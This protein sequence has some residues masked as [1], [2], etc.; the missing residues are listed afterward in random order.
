MSVCS[1]SSLLGSADLSR[2][3]QFSRSSRLLHL[4]AASRKVPL[5]SATTFPKRSSV[6]TDACCFRL[7]SMHLPLHS[8]VHT[9]LCYTCSN[10]C[11]FNLPSISSKSMR[12]NPKRLGRPLAMWG[13]ARD[14]TSAFSRQIIFSGCSGLNVYFIHSRTRP[15]AHK[16]KSFVKC[17]GARFGMPLFAV[18]WN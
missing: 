3:P 14:P 4:T 10:S 6:M 12:K 5:S 16:C 15:F 2:V 17:T 18:Q 8:Y 13:N 1:S 9:R 7:L 11:R